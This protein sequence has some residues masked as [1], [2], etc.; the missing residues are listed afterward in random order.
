VPRLIDRVKQN[1]V[2]KLG[3]DAENGSRLGRWNG[4]WLAPALSVAI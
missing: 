3:G 2:I 4:L 1:D